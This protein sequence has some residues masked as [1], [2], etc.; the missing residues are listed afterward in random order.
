M[1]RLIKLSSTKSTFIRRRHVVYLHGLNTGGQYRSWCLLRWALRI[2]K[3]AAFLTLG[4][5]V[6][7][8]DGGNDIQEVKT[9]DMDESDDSVSND[10]VF[11]P[12]GGVGNDDVAGNRMLV[13]ACSVRVMTG[14]RQA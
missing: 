10:M 12:G 1:L 7:G 3:A 5:G 9:G 14:V 11:M 2:P 6:E 4:A 13:A 8:G